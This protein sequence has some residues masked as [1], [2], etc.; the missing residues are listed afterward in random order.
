MLNYHSALIFSLVLNAWISLPNVY[1]CYLNTRYTEPSFPGDPAS[2]TVAS[3]QVT[4]ESREDG[5]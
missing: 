4:K 5:S 2:S 1:Y 3:L